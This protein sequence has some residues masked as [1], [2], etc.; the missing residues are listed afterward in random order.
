VQKE[1]KNKKAPPPSLVAKS[2]LHQ[3]PPSDVSVQRLRPMIPDKPKLLLMLTRPQPPA[4]MLPSQGTRCHSYTAWYLTSHAK[5]F[6][7]RQKNPGAGYLKSAPHA[8]VR[9][10]RVVAAKSPG[11]S[12]SCCRKVGMLQNTEWLL[13]LAAKALRCW[14]LP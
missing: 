12:V 14:Q 13:H 11:S 7:R 2:M 1:E 6:Q 8:C 4:M 10:E 3:E 5:D 9:S